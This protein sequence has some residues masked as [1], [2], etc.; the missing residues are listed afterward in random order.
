MMPNIS[1]YSD[2]VEAKISLFYVVTCKWILQLETISFFSVILQLVGDSI[3]MPNISL[4]SDL[5]EA[6][7]SLFYVVT[8]KWILQL[9][10]VSFF[11]VILSLETISFFSMILQLE[12]VSFFLVE[13]CLVEYDMLKYRPSMLAASAVYTGQQ[14]LRRFPPWNRTMK[15]YTCYTEG[16]LQ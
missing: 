13:L 15:H 9:E 3:F 10:T 8:C 1:L 11:S 7:I 6:N 5:V 12:T 2:L 4:Y 14:T 16:Q